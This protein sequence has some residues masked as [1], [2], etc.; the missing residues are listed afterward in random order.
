MLLKAPVISHDFLLEKVKMLPGIDFVK[1]WLKAGYLEK[2]V[3]NKTSS[4]VPQGG[5]I[6]P[7]LANIAGRLFGRKS[8]VAK[9]TVNGWEF[10]S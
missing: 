8:I 3:F 10:T 7:L 6:S 4:G 9:A 1:G 5:I 2:E